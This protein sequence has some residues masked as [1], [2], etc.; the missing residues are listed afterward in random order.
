METFLEDFLGWKFDGISFAYT[1]K[2][3]TNSCFPKKTPKAENGLAAYAL[4]KPATLWNV[5]S[6]G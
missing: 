4:R 6:P 2:N 1:K 3:L 5:G